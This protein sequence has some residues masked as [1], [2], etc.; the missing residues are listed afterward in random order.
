MGTDPAD[1]ASYKIEVAI[2]ENLKVNSDF[3]KKITVDKIKN[4]HNAVY[5]ILCKD[6][7]HRSDATCQK[8][9]AQ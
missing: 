1:Q 3:E 8:S 7:Q 9:A 4:P 2:T 6:M 5:E